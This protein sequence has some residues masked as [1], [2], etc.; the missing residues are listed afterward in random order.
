MQRFRSLRRAAV[1][2]V[3]ALGLAL[4]VTSAAQ[5][6]PF[7]E[8]TYDLGQSSGTSTVHLPLVPPVTI[9]LDPSNFKGQQTI[10]YASDS[11]SGIVPGPVSLVS[12]YL[13]VDA[14]VV[15]SGGLTLA[16]STLHLTMLGLPASGG[17]LLAGGILTPLGQSGTLLVTGIQHCMALCAAVG[18]PLS[19]PT[20]IQPVSFPQPLPTLQTGY[21]G[22]Q[23][24]V[25][26]TT[27]AM[28]QLDPGAPSTITS[29]I[30]TVTA[31][32]NL[33]G[34]EISRTPVPEPSSLLL[35]GLGLAGLAA[36][37]AASRRF[38]R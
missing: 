13:T 6:A 11:A 24:S 29:Q 34:R 16:T 3:T 25:T 8:V 15:T 23:H 27:T 21:Y 38:R 1:V 22:T 14:P 9:T 33:V 18:V 5:A 7:V 20:L 4:L 10:R 12:F 37:G 26:G 19:S 32:T 36:A 30:V 2:P 28:F 31:V 17:S 35:A